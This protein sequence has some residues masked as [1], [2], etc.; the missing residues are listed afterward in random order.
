MRGALLQIQVFAWL[1]WSVTAADAATASLSP[2]AEIAA[3]VAE[4]TALETRPDGSVQSWQTGSREAGTVVPQRTW[5]SASGHYCRA[6]TKTIRVGGD[7]IQTPGLVA[8][9]VQK[10]Q[11]KRVEG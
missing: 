3:Q 2:E 8:C 11:W 7:I 10:G 5:K 4:Q 1:A 6:Y 9:R